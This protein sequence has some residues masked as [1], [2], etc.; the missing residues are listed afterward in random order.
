MVALFVFAAV[1]TVA[2]TIVVAVIADAVAGSKQARR[3]REA[4]EA[5]AEVRRQRQERMAAVA[6]RRQELAAE[7]ATLLRVAQHCACGAGQ[8]S[9]E[10]SMPLC[11]KVHIFQ[12]AGNGE[13]EYLYA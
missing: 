11:E 13:L 6:R 3:T 4:A 1:L 9:C 2:I 8:D 5:Q 10:G 7:G 12:H